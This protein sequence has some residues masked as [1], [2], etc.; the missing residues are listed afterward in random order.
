MSD[1]DKTWPPPAVRAAAVERILKAGEALFHRGDKVARL[2]EVLDGQVRLSRL[3]RSGHEVL[4]YVAGA[5]DTLAEASLF[6][7]VY[8]CDAVAASAATVRGYAKAA[9]LAA[10]DKNPKAAQA[11]TATLARLVLFLCLFFFFI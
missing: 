11:F 3:D 10:F 2:Y 5:G 9:V 8:H 7:P 1:R 4:L 6:S